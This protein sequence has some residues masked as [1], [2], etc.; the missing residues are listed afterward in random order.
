MHPQALRPAP[1]LFASPQLPVQMQL[2]GESGFAA[3]SQPGPRLHLH[4]AQ[5][6]FA[7]LPQVTI[8]LF[9]FNLTPT[10]CHG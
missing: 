6:E 8:R 4:P 7:I 2:A 9:V 10:P 1:A 3:T 5:P